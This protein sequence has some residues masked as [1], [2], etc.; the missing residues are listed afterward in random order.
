MI[1]PI[2]LSLCVVSQD[3]EMNP[4]S[5]RGGVWLPRLAGTVQDGFGKVDFE[6][7]INLRDQETVPLIEFTLKPIARKI[8]WNC[9][10][11][12]SPRSVA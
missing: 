2:L 9:I 5:L 10:C 12:L 4:A 8:F 6:T 1:V 3:V 7:N 11:F